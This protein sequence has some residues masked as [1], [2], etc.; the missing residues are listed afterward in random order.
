MGSAAPESEVIMT[1]IEIIK[2]LE[3]CSKPYCND[4][5]C[6]LHKNTINT[7]D[8]I[9]QLS[10]N[11]LDLINRQKAEIERANCHIQKLV[12]VTADLVHECDCAKQEAIKEFAERLKEKAYLTGSVSITHELVVD[13]RDI[14]ALVEEMTVNYE[15]TMSQLRERIIKNEFV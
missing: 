3:C 11:A 1:E 7:K 8:C 10:T 6:P 14:D 4:N 2:A 5:K 12:N 13:V 15:S 9:T